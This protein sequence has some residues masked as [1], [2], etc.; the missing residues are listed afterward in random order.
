MRALWWA[1]LIEEVDVDIR[2]FIADWARIAVATMG[3][4]T[5]AEMMDLEWTD[6]RF[7]VDELTRV[8]KE[9]RKDGQD[10]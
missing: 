6:Y 8:L 2:D 4:G 9:S 3:A 10:G 7:M 5:L 1:R